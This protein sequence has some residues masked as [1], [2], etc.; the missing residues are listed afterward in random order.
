MD[1]VVH[2]GADYEERRIG[3]VTIISPKGRLKGSLELSLRD[4]FDELVREGCDQVL[5][6]LELLPYLD[7]SELGRLIRCHLS[8]RKAGGRVR[9]CNISD[10]VSTLMKM[11]RLDTVLELYGTVEEALAE[12]GE[13]G[14]Q[15]GLPV[16]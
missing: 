5:I 7:S 16:S 12:I 15:D 8:V 1:G 10:K 6:N 2:D 11:T 4:R 9:I 14:G 13:P 3:R